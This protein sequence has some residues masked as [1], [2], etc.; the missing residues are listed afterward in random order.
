MNILQR[1]RED[2]N[3]GLGFNNLC[4]PWKRFDII[5]VRF[6][7]EELAIENTTNIKNGEFWLIPIYLDH[8]LS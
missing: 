2:L 1:R 8:G 5:E 7:T 4:H 3:D 6:L